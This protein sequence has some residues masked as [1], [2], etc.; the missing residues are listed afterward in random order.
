MIS[1][2]EVAWTSAPSRIAAT[3]ALDDIDASSPLP[4]F[5]LLA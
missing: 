1:G 2:Q 4:P 5:G 3:K